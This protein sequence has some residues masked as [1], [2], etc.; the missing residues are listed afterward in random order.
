MRGRRYKKLY[1]VPGLLSL[2]LVAMLFIPIALEQNRKLDK[3]VLEVNV[4]HPDRGKL[5]PFP[6]RNYK[7]V[8]LTRDA[9]Q[10]KAAIASARAFINQMYTTGDGVN[11][12]R[13]IFQDA[14]YGTYVSVLNSLKVDSIASFVVYENSIWVLNR[15][16]P[17]GPQL[18]FEC[19]IILLDYSDVIYSQ[20]SFSE[21]MDHHLAPYRAGAAKLWPTLVLLGLIAILNLK[22]ILRKKT[23]TLTNNTSS[24]V[25]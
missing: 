15:P 8:V 12:I 9:E 24:T 19:D 14:S 13:Y 1:Y 22:Q 6:E 21:K 10:N 3:R 20:M 5:F 16:K 25:R 17:A 7:P 2:L 18:F 23:Y 4:W 11:G